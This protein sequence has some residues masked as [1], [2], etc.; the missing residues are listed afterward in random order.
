MKK[1][2]KILSS[3]VLL[4][5]ALM[6]SAC[7]LSTELEPCITE[8]IL[9]FEYKFT[10]DDNGD[11]PDPDAPQLSELVDNIQ[12]YIFDN[13]NDNKLYA[14]A[15]VRKSDILTGRLPIEIL[16][17]DYTMVAWGLGGA[18]ANLA[19][20]GFD[21]VQMVDPTNRYYTP[22]VIGQ[23]RLEEFR[24][25]VV[26]PEDPTS[27]TDLYYAIAEHVNVPIPTSEDLIVNTN[28]R[29]TPYS[30]TIR[31]TINGMD[32]VNNFISARRASFGTTRVDGVTRA[33]DEPFPL[34]IFLTGKNGIFDY[35]GSIDALAVEHTYNYTPVSTAGTTAVVDI[36]TLRI[37]VDR[38]S[39]DPLVLHIHPTD[40]VTDADMHSIVKDIDLL[41]LIRQVKDNSGNLL[42]DEQD[43]IDRASIIPIDFTITGQEVDDGG[44]GGEGGEGGEGGGGG[45]TP[46]KKYT[47]TVNVEVLGWGLG[48]LVVGDITVG[49]R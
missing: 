18:S 38:H 28:F 3:G 21:N 20:G 11:E 14:I 46:D 44:D 13:N 6:M 26:R 25:L 33:E 31:L 39:V 22:V 17:G 10:I 16:S 34:N 41:S 8:A 47:L 15:S 36:R 42:L 29:F 9:H 4:S 48:N 37:D 32:A 2:R 45:E 35:N 30:N 19:G 12:L 23:T 1:L 7:K 49:T 27:F 5:A 40:A 24:T 43:E